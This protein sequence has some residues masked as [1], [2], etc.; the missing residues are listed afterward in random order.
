MR[1]GHGADKLCGCVQPWGW[2]TT[3]LPKD[4]TKQNELAKRTPDF[5]TTA[6]AAARNSLFWGF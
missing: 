5:C 1:H 4:I 2:S 3:V 6:S